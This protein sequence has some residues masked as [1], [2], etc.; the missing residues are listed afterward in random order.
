MNSL[1]GQ[2]DKGV[3]RKYYKGE[4]MGKGVMGKGVRSLL[5]TFKCMDGE[6]KNQ[7][8]TPIPTAR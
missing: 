1:A 5:L 4:H 3:S 2:P 6:V 7:D 8:L